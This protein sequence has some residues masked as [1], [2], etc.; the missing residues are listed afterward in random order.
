MF[1]FVGEPLSGIRLILFIE[2]YALTSFF[3][4]KIIHKRKQIKLLITNTYKY[5]SNHFKNLQIAFLTKYLIIEL[6]TI[7]HGNHR[8]D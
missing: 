5:F 1:L 4:R 6:F 3:T 8:K 7:E 2:I